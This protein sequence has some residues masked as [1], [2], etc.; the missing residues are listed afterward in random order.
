M[1]TLNGYPVS[2]EKIDSFDVQ[3]S[4]VD[5]II[6]PFDIYDINDEYGKEDIENIASGKYTWVMA[7]VTVYKHGIKLAS[8]NLG[9][10]EYEYDNLIDGFK[11]SGYYEDMVNETIKEARDIIIKLIGE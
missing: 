5:E 6:S 9:C 7:I 8:N 10:C 1:D 11:G 2:N 4:F 3:L